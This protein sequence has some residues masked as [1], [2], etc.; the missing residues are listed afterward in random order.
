MNIETVFFDLGKV[1][2]DFDFN[3]AL[4]RVRKQSPLDEETMIERTADL[5]AIIDDYET[6]SV[7]TEAF[8]EALKGRFEFT[9][10]TGELK[11]IWQEIFTPLE[12]HIQLAR[13]VAHYYPVALISNTSEAHIEYCEERFEFMNL[14]RKK[15]YSF[16]MG[17]MKPNPEIYLR[18]LEE[19]GGDRFTTL[20]IDDREEN[21][22]TPSKM[23]W[24]TIH[25]RPDVNLRHALQ[26]YELRGV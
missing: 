8:F 17:V 22:M 23:G 16:R 6:G 1:L 15:F 19:M 2:I 25:L 11:R 24:Q 21:I 7:T 3:I 26:S 18:A 20:F 14:F 13:L 4:Y 5:G 9:G 12:E 10:S